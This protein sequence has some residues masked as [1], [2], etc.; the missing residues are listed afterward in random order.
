MSHYADGWCQSG[1]G[2]NTSCWRNWEGSCEKIRFQLALKGIKNQERVRGMGKDILV[3]GNSQAIWEPGGPRMSKE[4]VM[5]LDIWASIMLQRARWRSWCLL[6]RK[7]PTLNHRGS[8]V[9]CL[10]RPTPWSQPSHWHCSSHISVS[11]VGPAFCR[12]GRS[13]KAATICLPPTNILG[14][15]RCF[16]STIAWQGTV[17][18]TQW[19][20]PLLLRA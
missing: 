20:S 4:W 11:W 10:Q 14:R 5:S 1:V 8:S 9:F 18:K 2:K 12:S 19:P 15:K 16:F 7:G 17:V 13:Q 3:G 6:L